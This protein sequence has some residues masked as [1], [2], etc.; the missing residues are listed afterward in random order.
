M[1]HGEKY[2]VR[3]HLN[4]QLILDMSMTAAGLD[5]GELLDTSGIDW[6][7]PADGW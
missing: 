6:E 5:L 3:A 2:T 4:G 7:D 1:E